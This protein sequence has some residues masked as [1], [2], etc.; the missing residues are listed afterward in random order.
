MQLAIPERLDANREHQQRGGNTDAVFP[1]HYSRAL[2]RAFDLLPIKVWGLPGLDGGYG[3]AHLQRYVCSIV[4]NALSFLLTGKLELAEDLIVPHACD[5]HQELGS[6][7]ID[8]VKPKQR[9]N[10]QF[11]PRGR[12][13]HLLPAESNPKQSA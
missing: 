10:P 5:L 11:L 9:I 12:D 8:F 7:L 3:A 13:Y 6:F 1:I 4:H 2:L